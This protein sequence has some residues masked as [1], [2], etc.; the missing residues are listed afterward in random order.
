MALFQ[1]LEYV[2]ENCF[3]FLMFEHTNGNPS[4]Y[5]IPMPNGYHQWIRVEVLPLESVLQI[6]K[7]PFQVHFRSDFV[8]ILV[9]YF[10]HQPTLS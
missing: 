6:W 9:I 4:K 8:I 7:G 1:K 2:T 3:R 10:P 5:G